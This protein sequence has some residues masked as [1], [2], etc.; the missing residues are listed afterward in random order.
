MNNVTL[1]ELKSGLTQKNSNIHKKTHKL[2]NKLEKEI[3]VKTHTQK[4]LWSNSITTKVR[5]S[6]EEN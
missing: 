2:K 6:K 3:F 1:E 4:K 5:Q